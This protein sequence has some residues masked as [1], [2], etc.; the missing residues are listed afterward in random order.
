MPK[1]L[2]LRGEIGPVSQEIP[3]PPEL[4]FSF[5]SAATSRAWQVVR[6]EMWSSD[7]GAGQAWNPEDCPSFWFNLATDVGTTPTL[8]LASD[9]RLIG[10]TQIQ[11]RICGRI[12]QVKDSLSIEYSNNILDPDH[13]ITGDLWL[14]AFTSCI[15]PNFDKDT[16]WSYLVELK[17]VKVTPARSI[18][19]ALKGR[20]QS[21]SS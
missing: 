3:T 15:A 11:T 20:G 16:N 1:V 2:T 5:E 12:G 13:L 4:I 17:P 14:S 18:L 9:N 19:Y 10:W 21:V 7:S 8:Q 6:W